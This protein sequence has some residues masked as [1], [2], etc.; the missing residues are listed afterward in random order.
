MLANFSHAQ[1]T[2]EKSAAPATP[3]T[4]RPKSDPK[5]DT[6][7]AAKSATKPEKAAP[8]TKTV[9]ELAADARKS[10]VIVS[11]FG[12]DGKPDGVGAGFVISADGLI[13]TSLH[14]IG[15]ARPMTVQLHNGK[16]HDVTEVFAWDRKLDLA[17]VR[18]DADGL[19]PLPLG[20][21]DTLRP[22][23]PVVAIGNP[24][25]LDHSVVQG[26]VSARRDFDMVEMI[27]VA[28]PVEPGNS[29]GPLL[30]MEG[31]VHGILTLKSA[32]TANLGFAMPV[33][34]LKQ[35]LRK[36]NTVPA[37]RWLTIGAL[38]PAEWV[39][40]FGARWTQKSGRIQV[41]GAGKGFGGRALCVCQREVPGL[42]SE[43]QVTVKLDDEAGAAG[44]AFATDDENRHYG[45]YP[46][47]GRLRL[48]RFNGPNIFSWTVIQDIASEHYHPGDWNTLKVRMETERIICSVNGQKVIEMPLTEALEGKVGLAKFRETRAEFKGFLVGTNLAAN[49]PKTVEL[50][51]LTRKIKELPAT[52]AVDPAVIEELQT[53][54]EASQTLLLD[55][56]K[57]LEREAE[58]LRKLATRVHFEAVKRD[59]IKTLEGAEEK[60]D[61]FL[62]ALQVSRL[63]NPDVDTEGY[64]RELESMAAQIR[65]KLPATASEAD[66]LEALRDF[67]FNENGFHGSRTDYNNRANSYI[68]EVLDDREG[69]PITLAIIYIEL[70]RRLDVTV[71][72]IPLPGHFVVQHN[73]KKGQPQLIDVF[74]NA[75][76][77]SRQEAEVIV[78]AY[79][80]RRLREEHL[81]PASKREIIVRMLRNL[82]GV[83]SKNSDSPNPMKYLDLIVELAPDAALERW[84][85]GM[86][87]LQQGERAGAKSDFRWLLDHQSPG[88]DL[89]R[90]EEL[91]RR[92]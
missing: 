89:E 71:V 74:E 65:A 81:Q 73:P 62:A 60:T 67:L 18:I 7:P 58:Q 55:R 46:T 41:E 1:T 77:I 27:Q 48:T 31:R 44:L 19:S 5:S 84:S 9:V 91:Y 17:I 21:S 80:G 83:T 64:R 14:V 2:A 49:Q 70:A 92:L 50:A 15:E 24:H 54:S 51:S 40:Q 42:P 12:R 38:N 69:I 30:D 39:P 57:G 37:S 56:A 4:P 59:L 87:R 10:V 16:T 72:G 33:N 66:K 23:T 29:G 22:G 45:F 36:P 79:T 76:V 88:I 82:L 63:D 8:A 32:V 13:A 78:S 52:G 75:R 47:G 6:A 20:D 25:G 34:A 68:N 28:I 86:I 90:V 61:L 43:V 53:R 26:V 85:R 35:I 3:A 11:H